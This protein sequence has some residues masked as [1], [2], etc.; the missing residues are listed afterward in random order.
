MTRA[1]DYEKPTKRGEHQ[2]VS[3]V[4]GIAYN[5]FLDSEAGNACMNFEVAEFLKFWTETIIEIERERE[6][7]RPSLGLLLEKMPEVI[8]VPRTNKSVKL[9]IENGNDMLITNFRTVWTLLRPSWCPHP[10]ASLIEE[11]TEQVRLSP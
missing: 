5:P 11:I 4:M 10:L 1:E 9:N 7:E 2:N 8:S 6:R 3:G